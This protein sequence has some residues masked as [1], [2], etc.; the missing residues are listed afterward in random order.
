MSQKTDPCD[1]LIYWYC[2]IYSRGYSV[3]RIH[4][5]IIVI[6]AVL[7]LASG[8]LSAEKP[9]YFTAPAGDQPATIDK[10]SGV[11]IIPN[12]RMLTPW[13]KQFMLPP[14]PYGLAISKDGKTA[15]A[16]QTTNKP[17]Y[18]AIVRN[19]DTDKPRVVQI[20]ADKMTLTGAFMG[21]AFSADDSL[22]YVSAG[23]DGTVAIIDVESMKITKTVSL[24]GKFTDGSFKDAYTGDIILSPDGKTLYAIDQANF[25]V[26]AIDVAS[27]EVKANYLVGRYPFGL[28]LSPDGK[29]LYVV[30]SGMFVYS[31]VEGYKSADAKNTGL[32]FPP[33]GFPS[34][35]AR[36]GVT[37]DGKKVPGLGDPNV[38]ESLSLWALDISKPGPAQPVYKVKTGPKVGEDVGEYETCGGSSPTAVTATA[39]KVFVSNEHTD[40]VAVF[41]AATGELIKQISLIP[42]PELGALK[43]VMP[44]GLALS[45]DG[46]RLYVAEAGINAVGVIDTA[47]LAVLGHIPVGWWP[48]MLRVTADGSKLLV[49]NAKGYGS[50]PNAGPK[51]IASVDGTYVG[52]LMK[53]T[54]SVIPLP[55]DDKLK[56][57]TELVIK[58]NGF[59]PV[60]DDTQ[61]KPVSRTFGSPSAEIK[62]V[63]FITKENRTYDEV[64]GDL[65]YDNGRAAEG[66]PDLA[67]FG[68]SASVSNGAIGKSY[69]NVQVTPNHHALAYAYGI[70]DNFFVDSDVSIDGHHWLVG[71]YPNEWVETNVNAAYSG[72]RDLKIDSDAPGRHAGGT[73]AIEPEDYNEAGSI[74]EHLERNGITMRNWGEGF[75]MGGAAE[76]EG[77]EPTGVR[78]PLNIPIPKAL[79]DNTSREFPTFNMNIPDKYR[80]DQFIGEFTERYVKG[81]EPLPS[82]LNIYL[83][84]DHTSGE[85]PDAGYPF[86]ASF[87]ADNDL[88]LGRVI[89]TLSHSKYWKN[90]AVFVTEDDPQGGV[91]H[92]DAHRSILMVIGP[93]VKRG[94]VS[95]RHTSIVSIIKT[96]NLILGAPPLNQYDAAAADLTDFFTT[97]PDFAPYTF[98]PSDKRVFDPDVITPVKSIYK[99]DGGEPLDDP[100]TIEKE[101]KQRVEDGRTPK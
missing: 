6:T 7:F 73:C 51:F 44:F 60:V 17:N 58:N 54:L 67:R 46:S 61:L 95:H 37:I 15:A 83:P 45:P 94:Y 100:E 50:G 24:N 39:D 47:A 78:I 57:G 80:A 91:D 77:L 31:L 53:G 8:A 14:H 98:I 22:L 20:R 69:D 11:F 13:G 90:M 25:R 87:V 28:S 72:N 30:N 23:N 93:Y 4:Y 55:V 12:G 10:K 74:W 88:A 34:D 85:K 18:V 89:D 42:V 21:L 62:Y 76:W 19:L 16:L 66:L 86:R 3:K 27:F 48:S 68:M 81:S 84:N 2:E 92:V 82:F 49:T 43:G 5:L 79:F 35:E 36:D 64:F 70:G 101:H 38:I 41:N 63:V 1:K 99:L 40:T 71:T 59:A 56:E 75:E 26:V 33:F 97:E 9:F 32:D 29:I 65:K 52:R 96:I